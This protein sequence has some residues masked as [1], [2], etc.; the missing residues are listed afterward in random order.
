M[1]TAWF[2]K[3]LNAQVLKSCPGK[4]GLEFGLLQNFFI[5]EKL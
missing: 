1:P 4:L 2:T 5:L 3:T